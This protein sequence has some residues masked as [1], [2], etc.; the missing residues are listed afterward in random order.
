M[1]FFTSDTHYNH[2][3]I[4]RGTSQWKT[5]EEGSSRQKTRDFDTLEEHNEALIK[6]INNK[7]GAEDELW[8]L[9]D[10]SF[11]GFDSIWQF[12]KRLN[13]KHIHL[14]FGNHDGHIEANK[15]LVLP[16]EDESLWNN[17]FEFAVRDQVDHGEYRVLQDMFESA[18]HYKELSIDGHRLILCH[19]A[20][21]VWH[22]NHKN[23][24]MLFG[25]SHGTLAPS[26]YADSRTM[27]VG[28]DTRA[29][30]APY[31][32]E[33]IRK[34]MNHKGPLQGVDHHSKH[35]N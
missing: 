28:V 16:S 27:D 13:C 35:T 7:V 23:S 22:K 31:S 9:G 17:Y 1:I 24:I 21:R 29:D 8:H 18:Q 4:V 10:W 3:N 2:K 5:F 26:T 11:G 33:E 14:I 34:I 30:L 15:L 12:R 32:W 19:Y 6:A 20:M 25:H